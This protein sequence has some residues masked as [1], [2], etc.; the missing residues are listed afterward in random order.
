M[1]QAEHRVL[2]E[3]QAP[4]RPVGKCSSLRRNLALANYVIEQVKEHSKSQDT[5]KDTNTNGADCRNKVA[6]HFV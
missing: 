2:A 4:V 1:S 6:T 3:L 5:C